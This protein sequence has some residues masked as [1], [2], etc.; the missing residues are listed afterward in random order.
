[1]ADLKE[2]IDPN[3]I[4]DPL[5]KIRQKTKDKN[6]AFKLK[7]VSIVAVK[8]MMKKMKKKKRKGTTEYPKTASLR[9]G[10]HSGPTD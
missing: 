7:T 6:L 4:R 1:M 9:T 2:K 5:E 3:Q 8:K 10:G